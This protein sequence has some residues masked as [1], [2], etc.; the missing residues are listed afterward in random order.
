MHKR[1]SNFLRMLQIKKLN[2]EETTGVPIYYDMNVTHRSHRQTDLYLP[3]P[4]RRT[5]LHRLLLNEL[6]LGGWEHRN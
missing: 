6:P 4:P 1:P 5:S 3:K 2:R